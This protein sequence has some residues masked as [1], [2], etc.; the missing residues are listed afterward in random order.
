MVTGIMETPGGTEVDGYNLGT[1]M[2]A[3]TYCTF[4][5]T[6]PQAQTHSNTYSHTH[7]HTQ[8]YK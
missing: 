6:Q 4:T 5:F 2:R 3:Y 1:Q 7:A 8:V